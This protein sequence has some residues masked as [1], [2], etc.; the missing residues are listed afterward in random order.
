MKKLCCL[1]ALT[2][3]CFS[4]TY[5]AGPVVPP[6]TVSVADTTIKMKKTKTGVVKKK[7]KMKKDTTK[8]M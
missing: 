8:K 7:I 4:A 2:A 6:H 3:I 1:I 5:A